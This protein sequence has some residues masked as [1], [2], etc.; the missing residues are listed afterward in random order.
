MK[1]KILKKLESQKN[2]IKL[3]KYINIDKS[4]H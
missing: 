2:V 3:E 1:W 4:F